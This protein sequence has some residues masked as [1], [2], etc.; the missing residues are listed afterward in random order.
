SSEDGATKVVRKVLLIAEE[1]RTA[2][3]SYW[4][5]VRLSWLHAKLPVGL[6]SLP[7]ATYRHGHGGAS[8]PR[9]ADP[10]AGRGGWLRRQRKDEVGARACGST[11]RA[12]HRTRR[13][14]R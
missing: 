12:A 14:R 3:R 10:G 1:K 6:G 2:R 7:L 5:P 4:P 9:S 13:A 8:G 11:G